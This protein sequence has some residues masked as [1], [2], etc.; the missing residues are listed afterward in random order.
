MKR[1]VHTGMKSERQNLNF[2][3]IKPLII[4]LYYF[5]ANII[6]LDVTSYHHVVAFPQNV[7]SEAATGSV[8]SK[9][10]FFKI[11][12][13]SQENTGTRVAFSIKLQAEACNFIKKEALAQ[14][15]SCEFCEIFK[16]TVFT[17]NL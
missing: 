2:C 5:Q 14:M 17:E 7:F 10:V 3:Q 12:Q 9:K 1:P 6:I 8:L 11:S 13:N 4:C 16:S 15:F